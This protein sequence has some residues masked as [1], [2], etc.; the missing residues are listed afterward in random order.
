ML[1]ENTFTVEAPPD[2]V[3]ALMVDV[4]RVAPCLPGTEILARRDDGGYDGQMNLKLGPMKMKYK[5]RVAIDA[6]DPQARTAVMVAKGVEARG[7]GSAQGV[8]TMGVRPDGSGSTV[9]VTTDITI[10]G[11]VAQMGQGIMK[12]VSSKM[13]QEMARN[14]EAV[15]GGST[16]TASGAPFAAAPASVPVPAEAPDARRVAA[17]ANAAG[18]TDA[19]PTATAPQGQAGGVPVA[20]RG[21]E[22]ARSATAG[23]EVKVT[24]VVRAVVAGRLRALGRWIRRLMLRR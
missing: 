16:G 24:T 7:Q 5:G 19:M 18:A 20:G 13:V 4:E 3:F 6:Q 23:S 1:I 21:A 8:M 12:D 22:A 15:L 14:M 11:R 17:G 2:E 9:S 10:T